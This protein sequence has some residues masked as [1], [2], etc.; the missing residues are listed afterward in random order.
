MGLIT[1]GRIPPAPCL[2]EAMLQ[3]GILHGLPAHTPEAAY[4]HLQV[5]SLR[6]QLIYQHELAEASAAKV[7]VIDL[8]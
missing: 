1:G 3:P 6:D 7:R 5:E 8:C 2:C 4:L